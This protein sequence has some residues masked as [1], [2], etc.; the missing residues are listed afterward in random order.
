MKTIS[1]LGASGYA[2]G[3][4]LR[5]LIN[6]PGVKI[7]QVTSRQFAGQP[8]SLAHPNL[9]KLTD[10][11]FIRPD[12]LESCDVLFVA[13]P[14]GASMDLMM[15]L[16]KK[17]KK[18][19]D[20]GADF[21]LHK[22]QVFESWYR[23]KHTSPHLLDKFVYGIAELH[24][25]EIA[26]S[27]FIACAGCEATV[28]ILALYPLVK[29]HLIEPNI[30]IDAKM[31]SSQAGIKPTFSSH[32]P[33]RAGSVRSYMPTGHRHTAEIVQ[34][35]SPFLKNVSIAISATAI[36]MVRGLLVTIHTVPKKKIMEK[37]VWKA[38]RSEYRDEQF[39][40]I[41]KE[42]QGIYRYPEPKLLQGTNFCDIGFEMDTITNRLVVIAA[43]DNLVKGTAGQAVQALNIML[44][45]PEKTGLE[46]PGLHPI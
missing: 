36:D 21:R 32:H 14:N 2:G 7:K 31:S 40:R 3:E 13:L 23:K 28:S 46:F 1:I 35:L 27:S 33:E 24:R 25:S 45:I 20:L 30:I 8:V 5:I 29:H 26:K 16:S 4:I 11:V 38:Y 18:I 22:S 15:G 34:E 42:L 10:L 44:G 9:R 17:A 41:V 6:H 12:Q 19:I 39:I 37:D 43:I